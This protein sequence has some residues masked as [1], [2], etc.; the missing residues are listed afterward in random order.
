MECAVHRELAGY[1]DGESKG[2]S[3]R[4]DPGGGCCACTRDFRA[5]GA[6]ERIHPQGS[7]TLT[8]SKIMAKKEGRRRGLR[9]TA[10]GAGS[11]LP[12]TPAGSAAALKRDRGRC[13]CEYVD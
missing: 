7:L 5:S 8:A 9:F 11:A 2:G 1:S 13:S 10:R 6:V 12:F 3:R 4:P